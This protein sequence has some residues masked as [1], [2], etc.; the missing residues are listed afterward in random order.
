MKV[1]LLSYTQDGEELIEYAGRVCHKSK[2]SGDSG[3]FIRW[4]IGVGH[5]S[6]IEHAVATFEFFGISRACSH[7]VVRHRL[8][9]YSQ[10]SQRYCN[11]YEW[12]PIEPPSLWSEQ[13]REA[14]FSIT[15]KI[16]KAYIKLRELGMTKE[17]ARFILPNATPTVVVM[18]A[19]LREWRHF[20]KV[21]ADSAAQWEIQ[22]VARDVLAELYQ[23][24][25]NVFGDLYTRFFQLGQ[26]LNS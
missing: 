12:K 21:R 15:N 11:M 19:N 9:S 25:P 3:K 26:V 6:V 7:Q 4:L 14:F 17:D 13:R 23:R 10:E 5:E 24:F 2:M 8:A 18:T 16:K 22:A 1:K 20:I